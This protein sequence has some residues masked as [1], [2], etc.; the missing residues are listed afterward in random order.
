MPYITELTFLSHENCVLFALF[1]HINTAT[2]DL[3]TWIKALSFEHYKEYQCKKKE[4]EAAV[5]SESYQ[6][7]LLT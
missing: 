1:Q 5:A 7:L 4:T 2:Q 3:L 6:K